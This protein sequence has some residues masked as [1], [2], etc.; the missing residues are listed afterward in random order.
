MARVYVSEARKIW[1]KLSEELLKEFLSKARRVKIG[2]DGKLVDCR[3]T[4]WMRKHFPSVIK[5]YERRLKAA[6]EGAEPPYTAE[7]P[8]PAA[9]RSHIG[10]SSGRG[11]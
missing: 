2:R 1:D 4:N 6:R 9:R 3:S 10:N 5:E 7:T 11:A 8:K